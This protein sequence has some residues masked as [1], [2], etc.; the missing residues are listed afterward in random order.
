MPKI[1]VDIYSYV[2]SLESLIFLFTDQ[3]IRTAAEAQLTLA[4]EQQYV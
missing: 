1:L 2:I 4:V 3:A